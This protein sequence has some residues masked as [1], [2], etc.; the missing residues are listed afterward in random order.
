VSV[1]L[2]SSLTSLFIFNTISTFLMV[3]Y[4]NFEL[5]IIQFLLM[6]FL[7][8]TFMSLLLST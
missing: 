8:N 2:S 6:P 1:V 3:S 4:S 5:M 7:F